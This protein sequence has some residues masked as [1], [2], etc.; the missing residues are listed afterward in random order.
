MLP[1]FDEL[2]ESDVTETF[3]T[4]FSHKAMFNRSWGISTEIKVQ[5]FEEPLDRLNTNYHHLW[6]K[7]SDVPDIEKKDTF[8][9]DGV[10]YG[11]VDTT[12]DEH[13]VGMNVFLN[14]V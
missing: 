8:T 10:L 11:V 6:C 12:L 9:I 5:F 4:E 1:T 14:K 13:G 3:L 2:V 7:A